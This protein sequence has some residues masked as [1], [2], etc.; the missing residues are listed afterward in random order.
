MLK[1]KNILLGVTGGIAAYKMADVAS[2]L[3]KQGADVHVV[4]TENATKF[5][6]AETF[7]VLTKNKV[8]VD[9][10]DENTDDYVNVPHI[11]LGTSADCVLI[12]PATA[13]VIGK[14]ANGIADDMVTTTV[15]P[16]RCP[17]LIA[18]SMNVYMLENPI[19]QDNIAKLKKFGYTIIEPASGHLACGYDGKGKLP[20]PEVLVENVLYAAAKEKD[21]AG[22]KVLVDAGPTQE[23][24]DP[25]RY[26]T[27]HSSG[28][29]GYA[30]ARVAAMRGA[31]V[32]LVSGP[33][34]LS[35][36]IGV[37]RIDVVSAEDMYNAMVDEALDSDIIVMSAA[38]ADF[39]PET[40]ADNKIKKS[41]DDE[42][43]VIPLVRT[44][45][46]LKTLGTMKDSSGTFDITDDS[47]KMEDKKQIIVGF[48]METENLLENSRKKLDSKNADMICANSLTTEGAGYQ[49]DT[50]IVT[51][52]TKN[53]MIQLPLLSK[54]EVADR[55]L[56]KV[57]QL[58]V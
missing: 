20:Q 58:M 1:G 47:L 2:L 50:N 6:P 43:M 52:I 28:K 5:I 42:G 29:M 33:T 12:A 23:A 16:A 31:E 9:V 19:V 24:I 39:T 7:Q 11:S 41:G 57:K 40:V 32:T 51:M 26:I 38:V 54:D 56:D 53:E 4:M 18:P 8:Y 30:V 55:I 34:N 10:F 25:V 15:L 14:I 45:D 48:S 35:T 27:N 13:D 44:K 21:L 49:V 22:K 17:I 36:P 3:V 46:I 37:K